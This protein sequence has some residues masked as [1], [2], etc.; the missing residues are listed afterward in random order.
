MKTKRQIRQNGT[1]SRKQSQPQSPSAKS[2]TEQPQSESGLP[3]RLD[4]SR[5]LYLD[6]KGATQ[7]ESELSEA[8]LHSLEEGAARHG[9][10]VQDYLARGPA[11]EQRCA[12][13][14]VI[15]GLTKASGAVPR[16]RAE[17]SE[18][19]IPSSAAIDFIDAAARLQWQAETALALALMNA[20]SLRE[21][22]R[23]F[24][25]FQTFDLPG[26]GEGAFMLPHSLLFEFR[27]VF[28][29]WKQA[30]EPLADRLREC[31]EPIARLTF[32]NYGAQFAHEKRVM[33]GYEVEAGLPLALED[34]IG[35]IQYCLKLHGAVLGNRNEHGAYQCSSLV[36][37]WLEKAHKEARE[38]ALA[39]KDAFVAFETHRAAQ[40]THAAA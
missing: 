5:L 21:C 30:Y 17:S 35:S 36:C 26:V 40:E 32:S 10:S 11:M 22:I 27:D 33:A 1:H 29:K 12:R 16:E 13:N 3:L 2:P 34:V 24:E 38:S 37:G 14:L 7:A 25:N 20:E 9:M 23:G 28:K 15:E 4:G 31:S 39:L 18:T 6:S 8:E 19:V